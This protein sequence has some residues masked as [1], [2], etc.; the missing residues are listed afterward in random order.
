MSE[1]TKIAKV[2]DLKGLPCPFPSWAR[3]RG[4]EILKTDQNGE[5]TKFY[6]KRLL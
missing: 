6:I 4:H 3:T 2:M 5:V 1:E